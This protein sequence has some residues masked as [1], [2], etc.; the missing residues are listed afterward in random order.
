L[1]RFDQLEMR[2]RGQNEPTEAKGQIRTPAG[3]QKEPIAVNEIREDEGG[4]RERTKRRSQNWEEAA[5]P[6]ACPSVD[7]AHKTD[8]TERE[9][10]K[11]SFSGIVSERKGGETARGSA[12][13]KEKQTLEAC[14]TNSGRLGCT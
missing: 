11:R 8:R 6:H 2:E 7:A 12:S 10:K 4:A 9:R 1:Q 13:G 3:D 14:R 5:N